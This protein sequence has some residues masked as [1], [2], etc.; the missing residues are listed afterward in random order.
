[1]EEEKNPLP[2][3]FLVMRKRN[4][5]NVFWKEEDAKDHM[6]NQIWSELWEVESLEESDEELQRRREIISKKYSVERF[7]PW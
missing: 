6:E 5:L 3:V 1:M 7:Q 2:D 4:L